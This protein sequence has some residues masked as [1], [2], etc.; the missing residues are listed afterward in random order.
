[1]YQVSLSQC[2]LSDEKGAGRL[3]RTS[4]HKDSRPVPYAA[5]R[6]RHSARAAVRLALKMARLERLRLWLKWFETEA[7]TA[8]NLEKQHWQV[9]DAVKDFIH[10]DEHLA[11][12]EKRV[13]CQK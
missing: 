10:I 13:N 2:L 5:Q 11:P 8:A 7:W 1:M 9:N 4:L 12:R 6:P 3:I